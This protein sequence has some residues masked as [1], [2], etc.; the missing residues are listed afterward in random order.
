MGLV[1]TRQSYLT[2]TQSST[3]FFWFNKNVL[4]GKYQEKN[5]EDEN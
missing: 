1:A 2:D 5:A 3:G 4:I